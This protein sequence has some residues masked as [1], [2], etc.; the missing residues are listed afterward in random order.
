MKRWAVMAAGMLLVGAGPPP[1]ERVVGGDGVVTV[2]I[3][4]KAVRVRIDPAAPGMPLLIKEVA[5]RLRFKESRRLGVGFVYSVGPVRI[6]SSTKVARVDFGGGAEK[7]R[8]GW[9]DRPFGPAA[10]GSVGPAGL[11]ERV[12]RFALRAPQAGE[13]TVS[14]PMSE[15]GFPL[16]IFGSGW[17]PSFGMINVGGEPL[18]IRFDPNHPRSLATAGAAVRIAR[19]FGGTLAGEA[20]PTEIFFG[21]ERPVRTMTL[22][23]P[24]AVAGLSLTT[25]GVRIGDAGNA[26]AIREAGAAVEAGDP[27]EVVVTGKGKKRDVRRD[28]VSLGADALAR[29]SSIVFDKPAK[30]IRLSCW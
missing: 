28:V 24:M 14:L 26:G 6:M 17:V 3:D 4:G 7:Q 22:A 16:N 21:I 30:R 5:D 9:A 1:A 12:I 11:P 10:E 25:L 23:R 8:M 15:V 27:D 13:R 20:V 19:A 29:C 18:R 2:T